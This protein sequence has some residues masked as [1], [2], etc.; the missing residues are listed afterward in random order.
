MSV[1]AVD[2]F[3]VTLPRRSVS[4]R[5]DGDDFVVVF[6]AHG[7]VAFRNEDANALRKACRWLRY[8]ITYDQALDAELPNKALAA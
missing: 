8:T 6:E 2:R 7:I 1:A 5:R 3:L 4:I